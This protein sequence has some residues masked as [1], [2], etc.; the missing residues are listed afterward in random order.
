MTKNIASNSFD[1]TGVVNLSLYD[2]DYLIDSKKIHNSGTMFLFDFFAFCLMGNF[3]KASLYRPTKVK[4]LHVARNDE[5]VEI[6]SS[7]A[8]GFI[9]LRTTPE[10]IYK[11][12]ND[13]QTVK[14]SFII[15]RT[16][17]SNTSFNRICLYAECITNEEN[18]E[19]S[20][21]C[22]L[23]DA[24]DLGIGS[25]ATWSLSSVLAVDWELTVSNKIVRIK[26]LKDAED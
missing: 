2:G 19:Y 7:A 3:D 22:D 10:L 17:I 23:E 9:Y 13:G 5:G 8:S 14:L 26:E 18:L 4:L 12:G 11:E 24:E 15:P 21:Y 25:T 6:E 20:A 1:Y 16:L